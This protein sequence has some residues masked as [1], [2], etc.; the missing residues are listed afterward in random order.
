MAHS[1]ITVEGIESPRDLARLFSTAASLE[2]VV[3]GGRLTKDK[4]VLD[5]EPGASVVALQVAL[6]ELGLGA[7][8]EPGQHLLEGL[9]TREREVIA[10]LA[11]GL[12]LKEVAARMGIQVHTAREY[13]LRIKRKWDVKS[14]G[15]AVRIWA[16][17]S[18]RH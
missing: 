12:Q 18:D 8:V 3:H 10:N 6:N 11:E 13:W 2:V 17:N 15:Q 4:V 16:E 9:S 1:K 14:I 5:L 7:R